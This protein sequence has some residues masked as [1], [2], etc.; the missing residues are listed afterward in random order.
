MKLIG[1]S[2]VLL[3]AACAPAVPPDALA[4]LGGAMQAVTPD[5][6]KII[7]TE[8][9]AEANARR[10]ASIRAGQKHFTLVGCQAPDIITLMGEGVTATEMAATTCSMVGADKNGRPPSQAENSAQLLGLIQSYV[11]AL[12][13]LSK[14]K[15]PAEIAGSAEKMLTAS[16]KAV[17]LT[18]GTKPSAYALQK[19]GVIAAVTRFG[20]ERYRAGVLR[21]T[22]AKAR[23]PFREAVQTL[24]SYLL[25]PGK[26]RDPLERSAA[27]LLLAEKAA[28]DAPRDAAKVAAL[29][30]AF[31]AD[32]KVRKTSPS[33]RLL[34]MLIVHEA[35]ADQLEGPAT[36]DEVIGLVDELAKLRA[37]I[38]AN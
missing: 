26:G 14:S 20:L 34:Q 33:V 27:R 21:R 36:I 10:D 17:E 3:L 4:P 35:L 37:M 18:G 13:S 23:D 15:L 16:S 38:E 31:A 6:A 29:E 7:T 11:A 32:A 25:E 30:S 2:C 12:D 8:T 1:P 9:T 19:P 28:A 24:T 22:V 5:I